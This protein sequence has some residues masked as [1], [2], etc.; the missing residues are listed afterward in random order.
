MASPAK[1]AHIALHT[2]DIATARDWYLKVLE[3]RVLFENDTICFT[4]YD[5]EH[6]RVVF[7]NN[8][9]FQKPEKPLSN[10]T[11]HHYTFTY[12]HLDELLDKYAE[13][14]ED[15]IEPF[16]CLNHGPTL[17][18]YYADPMNNALELQIDTMTMDQASDF[19]DANFEK[20]PIGINFDPDDLVAR[21][22]AGASFSN[23]V[24]YVQS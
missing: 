9:E 21:R 8:P 18:M 23:I 24:E 15:S 2:T 10:G 11:L 17:S 7:V 14:K 1:F 19:I 13:L 22:K 6:H 16:I 5:A 3:A 20:N 12:A 4:S